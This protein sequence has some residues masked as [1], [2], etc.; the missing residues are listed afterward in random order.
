MVKAGLSEKRAKIHR[1]M[2]AREIEEAK[3][4]NVEAVLRD[5]GLELRRR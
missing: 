2:S 4:L 1:R 3:R 5:L